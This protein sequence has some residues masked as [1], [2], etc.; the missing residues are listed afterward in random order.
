MNSDSEFELY[1][2]WSLIYSFV[3]LVLHSRCAIQKRESAALLGAFREP[4]EFFRQYRK[5]HYRWNALSYSKPSSYNGNR[6]TRFRHSVLVFIV[7]WTPNTGRFF[8][9]LPRN[10]ILKKNVKRDWTGERLMYR[11]AL[12]ETGVLVNLIFYVL[13]LQQSSGRPKR[14]GRITSAA[15][16]LRS[17][18]NRSCCLLKEITTKMCWSS[19][20]ISCFPCSPKSTCPIVA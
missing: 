11:C 19:F 8:V 10:S 18:E 5:Q 13:V 3:Y 9:S 4:T 6:M 1:Y 15:K 7:Q 14:F 20:H 17:E 2:M 12:K 16:T